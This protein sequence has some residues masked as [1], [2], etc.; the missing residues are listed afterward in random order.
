MKGNNILVKLNIYGLIPRA[1]S[2]PLM[3]RNSAVNGNGNSV[4]SLNI[5]ITKML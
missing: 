1:F 5:Q 4:L 3:L 2:F